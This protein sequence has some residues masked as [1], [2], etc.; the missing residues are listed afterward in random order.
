MKQNFVRLSTRAKTVSLRTLALVMGLVMLL[1]AV[2]VG[3][4]LSAFALTNDG[5]GD[6]AASLSA[7]ADLGTGIADTATQLKPTLPAY[8]NASLRGDKE[9]LAGTGWNSSTDRLHLRIGSTWKDYYF[10]SAGVTTFTVPND[11]T[12]IEFELNFNGTIYKLHSSQRGF[13]AAGIHSTDGEERLAKSDGSSTYSVSGVYADTYTVT[14]TSTVNNGEV[15]FKINGTQSSG[16][17]GGGDDTSVWYLYGQHFGKWDNWNTSDIVNLTKDSETGYYYTV[18]TAGGSDDYFRVYSSNPDKHYH[19]Q[20]SSKSL[21]TDGTHLASDEG[22]DANKAYGL[23]NFTSGEK[24][25]IWWDSDAKEVW[26]VYYKDDIVGSVELTADKYTLTDEDDTVTFTATPG[27][28]IKDDNLTYTLYMKGN[29]TAVATKTT[30][31]GGAVTFNAITSKFRS[32]DYYVTVQKTG[33]TST[34]NE[35]TSDEVNIKNTADAYIPRYTVTFATNNSN[36]GTVTA[37]TADGTVVSGTTQIKEGTAV[38]ITATPK[39]G[40]RFKN[41]TGTTETSS[42]FTVSVYENINVTGNFALYGYKVYDGANYSNMRELPNGNWISVNSFAKVN[43]NTGWLT[44]Q[45]LEDNQYINAG[46]GSNTYWITTDDHISGTWEG[47]KTASTA[48]YTNHLYDPAYLVYSP[49]EDKV[50]LTETD[51]DNPGVAVTIKNGTIRTQDGQT[52]TSNFGDTT[53]EDLSATKVAASK[54]EGYAVSGKANTY[55]A[56]AYADA[57]STNN[58]RAIIFDLDGKDVNSG[59]RLKIMT[60]VKAEYVAKGYYVKGFVVSGH[61]ETYSV[62]WQEFDDEGNET[63]SYDD[64][65]NIHNG[66]NEFILEIPDY[67]TEPIEVTPIYFIRENK[68]GDN[69]RFYVDGFTGDV[70]KNWGGTLAVDVFGSDRPFGEYPGQPMINYNGRYLMD[71]PRDKVQGIT[72]NN[73][74]WDH[75]HSNL[76]YGTGGKTDDQLGDAI[77]DSNYQTYDFNDFEYI[78]KKLTAEGKDE[79]IIFSFRYKRDAN[80]NTKATSQLGT[81]TY[82]ID[83]SPSATNDNDYRK[84]Y[85]TMT[86]DHEAMYSFEPLTD[87]YKNRVDIFGDLVDL[88]GN[89]T[90]AAYNP[91]RIVSNGYDFN[92]AGKYATAWALYKPNSWTESAGTYTLADVIGGQGIKDSSGNATYQSESFL[93]DPDSEA[94]V[95]FKYDESIRDNTTL[96]STK[97]DDAVGNETILAYWQRK[98]RDQNNGS[99]SYPNKIADLAGVPV[100]ITYEYEVQDGKSNINTENDQGDYGNKAYRSDG[101]WYYSSSDQLVQAHVIVEYAEKEGMPFVR[102]YFQGNNVDYNQNGYDPALHTGLST[103]IQAYFTNDG[104]ET[105]EGKTFSNTSGYTKA[106]G[107]TDGD[108]TFDLKTVGDSNGDYTFVGW[109]LYTNGDYSFITKDEVYNSEATANDVYVARYIKTPSGNLNISHLLD[110]SSTGKGDCYVKAEI[111]DGTNNQN[112]VYTYPEVK[113]NTIKVDSKYIKSNSTY[114]LRITL[115]TV[116]DRF[117]EFDKYLEYLNGRSFTITD[118]NGGTVDALAYVDI[119]T[120]ATEVTATIRFIIRDLFDSSGNQRIKAM[121]FTSVL[122]L[123]EYKYSIRYQYPAYNPDFGNQAYTVVEKFTPE[124]LEEYMTIDNEHMLEF[125]NQSTRRTFTNNHAPYEDN[126]QQTIS[127]ETGDYTTYHYNKA[128]H[129]YT[130][131]I[132]SQNT[133]KDV[134]VPTFSFPYDVDA[135]Y[136]AQTSGSSGKVLAKPN[137][138]KALTDRRIFEWVVTSGSTTQKQLNNGGEKPVFIKAPLIIYTDV[139]DDTTAQ[140]FKYWMVETD[141]DYTNMKMASREYTRCYDP[142]F[143]LSLFQDCTITPVYG[144]DTFESRGMASPVPATYNDYTRFDPD[145]Q[146]NADSTNGVTITFIENSRNQYNY[147]EYGDGANKDNMASTRRGAGDRVYSDFVMSYNNVAGGVMLKDLGGKKCGLIIESV[148]DLRTEDGKYVVDNEAY[149]QQTYG[150]T[151]SDIKKGAEK[152]DLEAYITSDTKPT[153]CDKVEF[154]VSKLDNKNRMQYYYSLA[155]RAHKDADATDKT[156]PEGVYGK[157]NHRVFR[158]YA[159]IADYS[160]GSYSNVKISE[161]PVYFTINDIGSIQ[162]GKTAGNN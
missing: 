119:D 155:N 156:M 45:R 13:S 76:F 62:L 158:A 7:A 142:E 18:H 103:G 138:E 4:T 75:A 82:Y 58:P 135:S 46:A 124:E 93:I 63:T 49:S 97:Y 6:Q 37:K 116:P 92:M 126:F 96:A 9:D 131:Q 11:N 150:A 47:K 149:Y 57:N 56:K 54:V 99:T 43:D 162:L 128:N 159:Y 157:N 41:W 69:V 127:F 27:G 105:I 85:S 91:L 77:R 48:Y 132:T 60:Q 141:K 148:A 35:V 87:F 50:W 88:E 31:T 79:D 32:Q 66:Y 136:V 108:Y 152:S 2:G 137:S 40:C 65:A 52:H 133:V 101:R 55:S 26:A 95:R 33:D 86:A 145:I 107:I 14:L 120:T 64:Y 104:E 153:G 36:Y 21:A 140:Y 28:T 74:V 89:E 72:M 39:A 68:S 113:E 143:N 80:H 147:G 73:Y 24:I 98:F 129:T 144:P 125:K 90:K 53:V 109:Y 15:K 146:R 8:A 71:I 22:Y 130:I 10:N 84:N 20:N 59:V 16:S 29:S 23:N 67:P 112:V 123:P 44:V 118:A 12:A 161:V 151:L 51:G 122:N 114:H 38:T 42:S 3:S 117:S 115:R 19:P 17:G 111:L 121:P 94:R 110:E 78:R 70:K 25:V 160:A 30:T 83:N 139:N 154:D 5:S 61:E 134:V 34:Y 81:A 1:S 106:N 102:D 100:E